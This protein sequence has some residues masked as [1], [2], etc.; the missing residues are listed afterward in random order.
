MFLR[1]QSLNP[2]ADRI[3]HALQ[4]LAIRWIDPVFARRH[5]RSFLTVAIRTFGPLVRVL[6]PN[7]QWNLG[8]FI[9][10]WC[11]ILDA[12]AIPPLPKPKRIFVF[13]CYRGQFTRDLVMALL[14]AWRG[15]H[16]TIGYL[17][18][19]QSPIKEPLDDAPGVAEYLGTVL[20]RVA[21]LTGGRV[22]CVDL[23]N[24]PVIHGGF[25]ETYLAS[26][27]R[28]DTVLKTR[29]ER[30]DPHDG[31][32]QQVSAYYRALGERTFDLAR[33]Y[34]KSRRDRIDLVLL[35][36][37]A[38][39]ESGY[40][41]RAAKDLDLPVNTHE[42]FAFSNVVVVN[43]GDAFFHF[44]DLDLVW[45]RRR[46]L[47]LLEEP[48][49]SFI[50]E[51]AWELLNQRRTSTGGAWGWQYQKG[52]LSQNT[53]RVLDRLGIQADGFVLVCPNVPF[54]SGYESWLTLFPSM[55]Q[56]LTE[57]IA[58]LLKHTTLP[59]VV[60]AHPAESRPG[61]G[62]EPI[63]NVLSEAGLDDGRIVVVPGDSDINT[64]DLMGLCRFAA[65][66]A[67]T[68]G[69]EIAMHRKPVIAG[70]NV[71]YARCGITVP[72]PSRDAYF[73]ALSDP[74]AGSVDTSERA[75][76]AA[77]VYFLF[78]YLLQ[79]RFPYDKPSQISALPPRL[80]PSDPGIANFIET[81]DVLAM[82][83]DE[84]AAA[85]PALVDR[86]RF[87]ARWGFDAAKR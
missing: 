4:T 24:T 10:D 64:Y 5:P 87:L 19:L 83:R 49:R 26:Q 11:R 53:G 31:E 74:M 22:V 9:E 67:S 68:T 47:G 81:L 38:S 55:R 69:V 43:H 46:E 34:L 78:H 36:N 25:D 44:S 28:A 12:P 84:F 45:Q 30:L 59:V 71:Y 35:A 40:F 3:R 13:S 62:R 65:V 2:T 57:T 33:S 41:C 79:W 32:V 77:M 37:G 75:D 52:R 15:H 86:A 20:G 80:L 18:K 60:R 61:Y 14:L 39:F 82:T 42:K 17:P 70:A 50:V 29:R 27:V 66:F 23:K 1:L 63:R 7:D 48:M 58:H 8:A 16:V 56:W 54:D 76:D 51:K 6:Q 73:A 72:A 21:T 85:L